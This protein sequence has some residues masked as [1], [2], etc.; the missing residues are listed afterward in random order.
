VRTDSTGSGQGPVV[1]CSERGHEPPSHIEAGQ[2]LDQLSYYQLLK[3]LTSSFFANFRCASA[4]KVQS[5]E[6]REKQNTVPSMQS[7]NGRK[8]SGVSVLTTRKSN[9][10]IIAVHV[11]LKAACCQL[12][13]QLAENR[14]VPG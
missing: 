8:N 10:T 5:D 14:P 1:G 6:T 2:F 4:R 9:S 3:K 13:P 11:T 12:Q 7:T